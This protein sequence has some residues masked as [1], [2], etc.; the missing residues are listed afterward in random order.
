MTQLALARQ[1]KH[2]SQGGREPTD[3]RRPLFISLPINDQCSDD[4][5]RRGGGY[6]P[7][8]LFN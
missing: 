1:K 2:A 4:L 6:L 7:P 5:Y 8:P 3:Y